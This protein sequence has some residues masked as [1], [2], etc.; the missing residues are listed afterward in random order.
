MAQQSLE[1]RWKLEVRT[2][3]RKAQPFAEFWRKKALREC[4]VSNAS[5]RSGLVEALS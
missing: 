3:E 1:Q 4:C 5:E 2:V